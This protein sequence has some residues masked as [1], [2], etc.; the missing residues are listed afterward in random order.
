MTTD[1][2]TAKTTD[3]SEVDLPTLPL[4]ASTL[5][6]LHRSTGP[7][8]D[9]LRTIPEWVVAMRR[10]SRLEGMR[11]ERPDYAGV[12][13]EMEGLLTRLVKEDR[14]FERLAALDTTA[15]LNQAVAARDTLNRAFDAATVSF[16]MEADEAIRHH[17]ADL[18]DYLTAQVTAVVARA[19][20]IPD[21]F[22]MDAEE[23]INTG[24]A[25][26][27]ETAKQ[28]RD[29]FR[30]I[31]AQHNDLAQHLSSLGVGLPAYAELWFLANPAEVWEDWTAWTVNGE[32][33]D[34]GDDTNGT[35]LYCPWPDNRDISD[36][37]DFVEQWLTYL[38]DTPQA[39]PWAPSPKQ[40]AETAR[41]LQAHL[42]KVET[43]TSRNTQPRR[44]RPTW[45]G[46]A[47]PDGL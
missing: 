25:A 20:E 36:R 40:Y 13:L 26:Q 47:L 42:F 23:A 30:L 12:D 24:N 33:A 8:G 14:S 17:E 29:E 45:Q 39:Q 43:I 3:E 46:F 41:N 10:L 7:L 35:P 32:L 38:V 11:P 37:Q 28:L 15:Q 22:F 9:A 4:L 2:K 34:P 27:W 19:R 1:H 16:A 18:Y 5:V 31:Y 6:P 21:A 44:R